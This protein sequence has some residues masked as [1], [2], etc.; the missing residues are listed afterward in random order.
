MNK[1]FKMICE[2]ADPVQ[3]LKESY[4]PT[5]PQTMKFKGCMLVSEQV[6]GN[7]RIYPYKVLKDEVDRIRTELIDTNRCLME[8]E[9][10]SSSEI[11][12]MRACARLLSLE[13]DNKTWV[14][15]GVVLCSDEKFGI[16]GTPCG[17]VL[18]SLANYGTKFG[19]SS[20][21]LG[22]VNDEG[23]VTELHLVTLDVVCNPSISMMVT[24]DGNRL[25]NG[26]LESKS[27]VCNMHGQLVE[28]KYNA[29]EKKLSRLPN[30][31]IHSKKAEVLGAAVSDFFR[32]LTK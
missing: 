3:L 14:G 25:V 23:V 30:T 24:S 31:S 9:H 28:Q 18:A 4:D 10:S 16:K 20:R 21:A 2:S 15:E 27:W 5:K 1:T 7:N 22:E 11:D 17:D 19:V 13:E 12:P 32:S 29:F 6:N 8:L 26:I